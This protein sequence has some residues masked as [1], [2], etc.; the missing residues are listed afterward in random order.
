METAAQGSPAPRPRVSGEA[1]LREPDVVSGPF[2]ADQTWQP[3]P[4]R[5]HVGRPGRQLH[6]L[7]RARDGGGAV[8]VRVTDVGHRVDPRLDEG[9]LQPRLARVPAGRDARAALWLPRA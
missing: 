7:L 8:P 1:A 9:A 3:P 6:S 4:A 5:C 2:D